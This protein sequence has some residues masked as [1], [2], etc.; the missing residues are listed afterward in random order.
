MKYWEYVKEKWTKMPSWIRFFIVFW[1]GLMLGA[2][3]K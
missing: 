1:S 3:L 2:I